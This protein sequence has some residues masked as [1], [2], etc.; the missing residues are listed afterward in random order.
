MMSLKMPSS[1]SSK[2]SCHHLL[3]QFSITPMQ[4]AVFDDELM[5]ALS[6][7]TGH[8]FLLSWAFCHRISF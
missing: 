3:K 5:K 4:R 8:Q 6:G 7:S 1:V 2:K